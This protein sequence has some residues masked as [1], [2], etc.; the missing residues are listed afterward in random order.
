MRLRRWLQRGFGW[1][2][3]RER[4]I[5]WWIGRKLRLPLSR[6]LRVGLWFESSE[7]CRVCGISASDAEFAFRRVG[8]GR[9]ECLPGFCCGTEGVKP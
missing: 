4:E 6:W 7:S 2:C 1:D 3:E 9:A 8:F 5:P